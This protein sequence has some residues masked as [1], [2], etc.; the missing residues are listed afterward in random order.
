MK[1]QNPETLTAC[2]LGS[3]RPLTTKFGGPFAKIAA[4]YSCID[5]N[6]QIP[7]PGK[8]LKVTVFPNFYCKVGEVFWASYKWSYL[9]KIFNHDEVYVEAK[10]LSI[11]SLDVEEA[12]YY[13]GEKYEDGIKAEILIEI[14]SIKDRL[15]FVSPVSPDDKKALQQEYHYYNDGEDFRHPQIFQTEPNIIR[16]FSSCQGDLNF[17]DY[18]YTDPDGIDHLIV[19]IYDE[20]ESSNVYVGD[21]VLGYHENIPYRWEGDLFIDWSNKAI[22]QCKEDVTE[23]VVPHGIEIISLLSFDDCPKLEKITIPD[24][25]DTIAVGFPR[26]PSLKE[27]ILTGNSKLEDHQLP[28]NVKI[29]RI[30]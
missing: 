23:V 12:E 6:K 2:E 3:T 29:T 4:Y 19:S 8:Q 26:C 1:K 15:S 10:L 18:I 28:Q 21:E 16:L 20:F 17:Y 11:L 25:V 22:M 30:P 9:A 14:L 27:I 13:D 5:W 7:E 24:S